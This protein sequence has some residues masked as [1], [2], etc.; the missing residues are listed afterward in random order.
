MNCPARSLSPSRLGVSVAP[1]TLIVLV[2]RLALPALILPGP[3]LPAQS[4]PPAVAGVVDE[5]E[6]LRLHNMESAEREYQSRV[7]TEYQQRFV[8]DN[9]ISAT[10]ERMKAMVF[11][12]ALPPVF[13]EP[14]LDFAAFNY[15]ASLA[16]YAGEIFFMPHGSL[17]L[18]KLLKPAQLQRIDNYCES[19]D[20]LAAALRTRLAGTAAL[21]PEARRSAL[22][23]FAATQQP[24]LLKLEQSA[25][26]LR[27]E[28]TTFDPGLALERER[29]S[30]AARATPGLR[31]YL[32][33]LYAAQFHG[34]LSLEQR[35]LLQEI[36]LQS[37]AA[38]TRRHETRAVYFL[39]SSARIR[40]ADLPPA[41]TTLLARFGE[42]RDALKDELQRAVVYDQEALGA[43]Q[44]AGKY[45]ALA[46]QQA[47]RFEELHRLAEEIR[48]TL[49][50]KSAFAQPPP[51]RL[52]ADLI[53]QV[54]QAVARKTAFQAGTERRLQ[55][56]NREF[57]P[58]R[59]EL[60]F[61]ESE[62]VIN[63]V[64]A[65]DSSGNARPRPKALLA[66]LAEIRGELAREY[67]ELAADTEK[68]RVAVE[69]YRASLGDEA[70][71]AT[72]LSAQLAAIYDREETWRRFTDYHAAIL[73]P[74]LSPAQRRLLF[75]ASLRRLE[76][77][78]LAAW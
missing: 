64:S 55:T 56:L 53:L 7:M 74:G 70:P 38:P 34:G 28:L 71:L 42:L 1:A 31:T 54:G 27:A 23:E 58:A 46:T 35:H 18:R 16:D 61:H 13:L 39:P 5:E 24:A 44:R 68:A 12:A 33:A 62:P 6:R 75:Q 59:F 57:A 50:E 40:W 51:S 43:A 77:H 3:F 14:Q 11:L 76:Q 30:A 49:P 20:A 37:V 4:L 19:R 52:P 26:E 29:N 65:A 45:S 41:S 15:P 66:R 17:R 78:R 36:A 47:P 63:M 32:S 69:S 25:E 10:P 2:A 73:I 60:A 21:P 72:G 9:W 67:H 48:L 22:A 8:Y